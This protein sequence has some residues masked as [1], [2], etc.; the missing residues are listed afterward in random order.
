MLPLVMLTSLPL[1]PVPLLTSAWG[2]G[3]VLLSLLLR[4]LEPLSPTPSPIP[5][6]NASA[7]N[8]HTPIRP[9][10]LGP[11][12]RLDETVPRGKVPI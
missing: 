11:A 6:P 9:G 3:W 1:P 8:S 2:A 10:Q 5:S 7:M 12:A 4:L